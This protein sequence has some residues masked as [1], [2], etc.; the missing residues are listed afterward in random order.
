[1][2]TINPNKS[3]K[4]TMSMMVEGIA[5]ENLN[6]MFRILVDNIEYGI[7]CESGGSNI[8]VLIPEL[9][10]MI[11]NIKEGNYKA[12]LEAFSIILEGGYYNLAWSGDIHIKPEQKLTVIVKEDEQINTNIKAS[13]IQEE[14]TTR[15]EKVEEIK[16]ES[17]QSTS[18][19]DTP[20]R[21]FLKES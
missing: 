15:H 9:N 12:K 19:V 13:L 5:I 8:D 10:K 20:F 7:A 18:K 1:M 6:F 2:I 4:L 17:V 14:S 3:K 16:N 11:P 21:N